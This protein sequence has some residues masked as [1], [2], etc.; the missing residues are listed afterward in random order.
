MQ[1]CCAVVL[2]AG[3]GKRMRSAH[4]KVL[5]P[6]LLKPMLGWVLESCSQAGISEV[7]LVVSDEAQ[8][9]LQ[10]LPTFF[11]GCQ[12]AVQKERRGTGHAVRA[13]RAFL[14]ENRGKSVLLLCGDAPFVDRATIEGAFLRHRGDGNAVTVIG[15]T[16]P[17]PTGYGRLVEEG[18]ELLEIVEHRD[19]DGETLAIHTV[20]SGS[21]WFDCDFLLEALEAIEPNNSQ[22]EYYLTDTV[23]IAVKRGRRAGAYHSENPNV[24]LGANDRKGLAHLNTVAR[25]AVLDKH[26]AAGVDI[27]LTD[28]ILIT[29]E[30]VIGPDTTILPGTILEGKTVI[31]TGCTIGPNT[32]IRSCTVGDG[33]VVESSVLEESVIEGG[34]KIGPF[35]R[36]R[37]GSTIGAG[38]K[39]GNFVE[40]KNS[41]IG[42]KT[43]VAHLSYLGDSD[44]GRAVNVGCGVVT[45]NYDGANKY[46]TIIKDGAFIGCNT[47]LIAPVAVGEGANIAAGT[48]V[49]EDIPPGALAIGR[50]R[51]VNKPDWATEKGKY[52]K[53]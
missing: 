14:E 33:A 30:V 50:V 51:Q 16:L 41:V 5:C 47:N 2:A 9:V 21:Y 11:P 48:T 7:C 18:G 42:P 27:P 37:P 3:D 53:R 13:A 40:I 15:A 10:I 28:G 24:A 39:I 8:E 34:A 29:P 23:A 12:T 31:G 1:N 35:T 38:A 6:V 4:S 36:V 26:Y 32:R 44:V 43:S 19:A 25:E 20:N 52:K 17:D 22:G 49:T 45:A 46:R